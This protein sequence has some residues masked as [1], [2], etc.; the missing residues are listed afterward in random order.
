MTSKN[1]VLFFRATPDLA[2]RIEQAAAQRQMTLSEFVRYIMT[3]FFDPCVDLK[4]RDD[5]GD[6]DDDPIP[7]LHGDAARS[8]DRV[9]ARVARRR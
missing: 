2:A 5:D 3:S 4:P 7:P 6:D 1:K 9:R 8:N